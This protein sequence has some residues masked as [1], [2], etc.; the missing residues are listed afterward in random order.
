MARKAY[1]HAWIS[2]YSNPAGNYDVRLQQI[3]LA[4]LPRF[5]PEGL[6]VSDA[7]SDTWVTEHSLETASDGAALVAFND[8]R[9]GNF[10]VFAYKVSS[11]GDMLWPADGVRLSD[12]TDDDIFPRIA[13]LVGGGAVFAWERIGNEGTENRV[14]LQRVEADGTL[15]WGDGIVIEGRAG[16]HAVYPGLVPSLDDTVLVTWQDT[17]DVMVD[18][19]ALFS[20]R[21]DAA[22]AEVWG[23]DRVLSAGQI[24]PFFHRPKTIPDG[25]GGAV[26]VW[27]AL[28]DGV[29]AKT[30]IQHVDRDGALTMPENG[31]EL[32]TSVATQQFLPGAAVVGTDRELLAAWR[33]AALGEVTSG[34]RAQRLTWAGER[35]WGDEGQELVPSTGDLT[36]TFGV[37]PTTDGIA[38]FS[39]DYPGGDPMTTRMTG[40]QLTGLEPPSGWE[41]RVLSDFASGK[42]HPDFDGDPECGYW[43]VWD[44]QRDDGGGV[45]ASFFGLR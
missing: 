14:V 28:P 13:P 6:L 27:T 25:D 21:L 20:R 32:S 43:V 15:S 18:E 30:Y 36:T 41:S 4:G 7:P 24:M 40:G 2:W 8:I 5:G 42:S 38:V 1:R 12:S 19:R 9:T 23:W 33:E 35:L 17:P 31:A 45:R 44:D 3:D 37:G 11:A 16:P 22:G 26:V 29:R 10:D 34:I 39:Y